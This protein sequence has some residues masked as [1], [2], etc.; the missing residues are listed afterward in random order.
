MYKWPSSASPFHLPLK[1]YLSVQTPRSRLPLVRVE[2]AHFLS[3]LP[4]DT[5]SLL[6]TLPS[7]FHQTQQL[8]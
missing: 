5:T 8:L 3:H 7:A 1:P 4:P 6:R 2:R